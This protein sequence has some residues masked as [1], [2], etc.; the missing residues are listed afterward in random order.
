VTPLPAP[1]GAESITEDELAEAL[2]NAGQFVDLSKGLRGLFE[3]AGEERLATCLFG[4]V[5]RHLREP[6]YKPGEIYADPEGRAWFRMR[7]DDDG[8]DWRFCESG[9]LYSNHYPERPLRRMIPEGELAAPPLRSEGEEVV[10]PREMYQ[11]KIGQRFYR[12][13]DD[14]GWLM[15]PEGIP[16]EDERLVYP[17]CRLVP[18]SSWLPE[19]VIRGMADILTEYTERERAEEAAAR[20]CGLIKKGSR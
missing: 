10:Q 6:E 14:T 15:Q 9:T 18:E 2:R 1:E 7:G 16:I 8:P 11:D 17:L 5:K 19:A 20:I 13:S 3:H 12:L 4:Y